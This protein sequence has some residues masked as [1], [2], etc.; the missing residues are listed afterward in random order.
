MPASACAE[1]TC[2][3]AHR[4]FPQDT[5]HA[6]LWQWPADE[7]DGHLL[8]VLAVSEEAGDA[9][10]TYAQPAARMPFRHVCARSKFQV[11][12]VEVLMSQRS[13]RLEDAL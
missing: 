13:R 7:L 1:L 8:P 10:P 3:I 5:V 4:D 6:W 12:C 9:S 11:F 2:R